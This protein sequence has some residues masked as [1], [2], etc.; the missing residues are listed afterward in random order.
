MQTRRK[1]LVWAVV[2]ALAFGALEILPVEDWIGPIPLWAS[3]LIIA[4]CWAIILMQ[5]RKH[6]SAL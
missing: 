4:V 6:R 1:T 5:L 2:A 3:W